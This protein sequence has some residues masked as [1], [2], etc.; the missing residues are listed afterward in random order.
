[1]LMYASLLSGLAVLAQAAAPPPVTLSC[2]LP[3]RAM[4]GGPA[5]PPVERI[6]R[7]G[8]GSFQEWDVAAGKFGGNL[9]GTFTCRKTPDRVEGTIGSASVTYTI[10]MV[11]GTTSGY[12]RAL[13]ASGFAAKEGVCRI[14]TAP[15]S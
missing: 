5:A 9:C 8:Q 11:T 13:G 4:A 3:A 15:A 1:M 12:W 7:V 6:F 14:I 10:G 2:S